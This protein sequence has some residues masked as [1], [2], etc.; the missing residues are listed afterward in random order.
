MK[1]VKRKITKNVK[2]QEVSDAGVVCA[3][4][5]WFCV[6]YSN[7]AGGDIGAIRDVVDAAAVLCCEGCM[8]CM[9]PI[10]LCADGDKADAF[11][12]FWKVMF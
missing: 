8:C 11:F 2:K 1:K 5:R 3:G 6:W 10:Y 4:E 12:L 9:S 7:G